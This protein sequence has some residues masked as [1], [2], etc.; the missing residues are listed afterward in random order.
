[1]TADFIGWNAHGNSVVLSDFGDACSLAWLIVI[2]LERND[3]VHFNR[4][5]CL[6]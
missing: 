3:F 1:M 6:R 4:M 2:S 5:Q